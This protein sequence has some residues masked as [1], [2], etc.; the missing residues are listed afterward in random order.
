MYENILTFYSKSKNKNIRQLSN[1]HMEKIIL[2]DKEFYS[3]EHCFHYFKFCVIANFCNIIERYDELIKH[4][5]KILN[6]C[7][8]VDVKKLGSKSCFK[9]TNEELNVWGLYSIQYQNKICL[10]KLKQNENVKNILL[11]THNKYL[12]HQDN[13]A[14]MNSL[15]GGKIKDNE[16]IGKNILGKIW[17][18]IRDNYK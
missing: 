13:R 4:S 14:N 11:E 17:M 5:I 9:L 10:E 3:G 6:A 15:W 7:T 12:L 8:P 1:F 18:S 16:L 2:E